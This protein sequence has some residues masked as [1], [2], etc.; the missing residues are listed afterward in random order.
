MR[1]LV[2]EH[3]NADAVRVNVSKK[4]IKFNFGTYLVLHGLMANLSQGAFGDMS[5]STVVGGIATTVVGA[6]PP[7]R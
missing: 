2:D 5:A 7:T 1:C 4:A 3:R 6:T